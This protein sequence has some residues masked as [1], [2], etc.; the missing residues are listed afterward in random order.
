MHF[1][2]CKSF[3]AWEVDAVNVRKQLCT[4]SQST[5]YQQKLLSA[6]MLDQAVWYCSC[7][8]LGYISRTTSRGWSGVRQFYWLLNDFLLLVTDIWVHLLVSTRDTHA[9][10][11]PELIFPPTGILKMT[12][13]YFNTIDSCINILKFKWIYG[14]FVSA[15]QLCSLYDIV[16]LQAWQST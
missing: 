2:C 14:I 10:I 15:L 13:I 12:V 16:L 3:V 7:K 11:V 1:Q 4:S 9:Y 6:G 5:H 8:Q